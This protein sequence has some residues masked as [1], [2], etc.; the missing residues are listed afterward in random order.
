MKKAKQASSKRQIDLTTGPITS[1]LLLFALPFLGS[2]LIQ[3]LYSTTDLIF[4]GQFIGTEASAAI[5]NTTILVTIIIGLFTG[6]G[7]GAST[8]L[9]RLFGEGDQTRVRRGIESTLTLTLVIAVCS[10][11]AGLLLAPGLLRLIH[12]PD[13]VFQ[14]ALIYL[15]IYFVG[16]IPMVF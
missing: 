7:I 16:M 6:L 15:R 2:S 10:V 12:T 11:A 3:Q 5:G 1:N 4:A 14:S 8:Y 9:A 13:T